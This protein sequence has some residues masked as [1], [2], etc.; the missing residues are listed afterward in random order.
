[1]LGLKV[2]L[3]LFYTNKDI[4]KRSLTFTIY[5]SYDLIPDNLKSLNIGRFKS[6]LKKYL[7]SNK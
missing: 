6:N 5:T 7:F 2:E 1:M 3:A 4:F